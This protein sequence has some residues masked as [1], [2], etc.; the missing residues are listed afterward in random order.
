MS[1]PEK[2]PERAIPSSS[3]R[4]A[5]LWWGLSLA[6]LVIGYADLWRGGIT[7][8]PIMLVLAYCILVPLAILRG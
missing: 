4:S 7:V 5:L 2:S 1:S 6:A 8:G 3:R